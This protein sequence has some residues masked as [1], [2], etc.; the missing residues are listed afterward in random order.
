M[1]R[2]T[3]M[4]ASLL[5]ASFLS[6]PAAQADEI[7]ITTVAGHPPVFLWV[8]LIPEAFIPAVNKALE[9]T[10]HTVSWTEAYGG[11]LAKV[12]GELEAME[13]GL[14][15]IGVVSSLFEASLLP[16]QN[17]TYVTPFHS[18]DTAVVFDAI[19]QMHEEIPD[20]RKLW[21]DKDLEYL[22]GGF[23]LED[24]FLMTKFPVASI[25]DLKG[26]KIGAP[27]P[28]VN[29][30]KET[31]AV[32]VSGNLTTYYNDLQTGVID[33]VI[34]FPT[35]AAPAK[36]AEQAKYITK[37]HFG[38]QYAGALVAKKS[39]YDDQPKEVQD[40]IR[41]GVDAY[42]KAYRSGLDAR[43]AGAYKALEAAGGEVSEMSEAERKRWADTLPNIAM[44]W[45]KAQDAAGLAG[46]EVLKAFMA[47]QEAAGETLIRD[48]SKE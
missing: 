48:W 5:A 42:A 2:R 15:Q 47:K 38:A 46:T 4:A 12:G 22:S 6:S 9:G 44:D 27:G 41:A 30:L 20:M 40:A 3:F 29:W 31:G 10:G 33:G 17:V 11:T 36:L 1:L 13:D 37:V 19:E 14:A 43:V 39:W 8:K 28:A 21:A 7:D 26:K 16:L 35:A 25:D 34:V 18:P 45:A 24:Y 32:G 23:G